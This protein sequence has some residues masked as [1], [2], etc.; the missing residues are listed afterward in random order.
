LGCI[1]GFVR[2]VR[3][4]VVVAGRTLFDSAGGIDLP[5]RKRRVGYVFQE[6]LLFP[7]LSAEQNLR[8]AAPARHSSRFDAV[9]DVLELGGVL[10]RARA[11]LSGGRGQRGAL[12]GAPRAERAVLLRDEPLASLDAAL[13]ERIL[14]YLTAVTFE[15]RVPALF[16]SHS[17]AEV[18]RLARWVVM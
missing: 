18:R 1:A 13:K 3:G 6:H 4:R 5:A 17:Q 15:F 9:V 12:G 8:F 10:R 7:H 14:D 16:V 11:Q 2:P